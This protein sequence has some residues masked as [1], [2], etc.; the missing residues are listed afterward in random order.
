M[1]WPAREWRRS[2][3]PNT[4]PLAGLDPKA[5]FQRKVFISPLAKGQ[6]ARPAGKASIWAKMKGILP[7]AVYDRAFSIYTCPAQ[8]PCPIL[9]FSL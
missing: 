5:R 1:R 8:E 2:R 7:V 6:P 3:Q 9:P 4:A